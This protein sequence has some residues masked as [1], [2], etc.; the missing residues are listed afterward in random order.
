[1]SKS[2]LNLSSTSP[3]RKL[4][5]YASAAKEIEQEKQ[6]VAALKRL[7]IGHL[8]NHDPDLPLDSVSYPFAMEHGSYTSNSMSQTSRDDISDDMDASENASSY[9]LAASLTKRYSYVELS[10]LDL[11]SPEAEFGTAAN[12]SASSA[13]PALGSRTSAN[14]GAAAAT[15]SSFSGSGRDSSPVVDLLR[16]SRPPSVVSEDLP[17]DAE[18]LWVPANV[19]PEVNPQQYKMH[20]KSTI[21]ELLEQKISRLLSRSR[22]KRSSLSFSVTDSDL[23]PVR[24]DDDYVQDDVNFKAHNLTPNAN[25][26]SHNQQLHPYPT[27]TNNHTNPSLRE[28]TSELQAMS[29]LA[30]MDATDA[31]TLARTLSSASMGYS[32][33]EKLAFDELGNP[34]NVEKNI[35]Q[36]ELDMNKKQMGPGLKINTEGNKFQGRNENTNTGTSK[37][38]LKSQN[39]RL[40]IDEEYFPLRRSRRPDYRKAPGSSAQLS[41][42]Q[43]GLKLQSSKAGK[44]AEL[45]QSLSSQNIAVQTLT[46][47]LQV[48]VTSQSHSQQSMQA[49]NHLHLHK[50]KQFNLS[51]VMPASPVSPQAPGR[52]YRQNASAGQPRESSGGRRRHGHSSNYAAQGGLYMSGGNYVT[53]S[54]PPPQG[55]V[56]LASGPASGATHGSQ[57]IPN[58]NG[59]ITSNNQRHRNMAQN[60][61][62]QSAKYSNAPVPLSPSDGPYYSPYSAERSKEKE[63]YGDK[64]KTDP[65][66][67]NWNKNNIDDR[68]NLKIRSMSSGPLYGHNPNWQNVPARSSSDLYPNQ[69]GYGHQ[70]LPHGQQFDQNGYPMPQQQLHQQLHQNYNMHSHLHSLNYANSQQHGARLKDMSQYGERQKQRQNYNNYQ[71]QP[72]VHLQGSQKSP[73]YSQYYLQSS[74]SLPYPL[75][76]EQFTPLYMLQS[77]PHARVQDNADFS[78]ASNHSQNRKFS[79]ESVKRDPTERKGTRRETRRELNE[80]LDLLRNEINEF[81][82]SLSRTAEPVLNPAT[83]KETPE[84]ADFSFDLTTHDVSYED[85]LGIEK[86]LVA[87]ESTPKEEIKELEFDAVDERNLETGRDEDP[88]PV[89]VQKSENSSFL[90]E[91]SPMES[92]HVKERGT[93]EE[94]NDNENRNANAPNGEVEH[95]GVE[96]PIHGYSSGSVPDIADDPATPANSG[97]N[98]YMDMAKDINLSPIVTPNT[99][100]PE[101]SSNAEL[102]PLKVTKQ[103]RKKLSSSLLQSKDEKKRK[104]PWPWSKE[105]RGSVDSGHEDATGGASVGEG[106]KAV[107][108]AST[109]NF[110]SKVETE[111]AHNADLAASTAVGTVGTAS[112]AGGTKDNVITK[113]FK[114]KRSLSTSEKPVFENSRRRSS[115]DSDHLEIRARTSEESH[116][117]DVKTRIKQK[118]KNMKK[119]YDTKID[120]S[121]EPSVIIE[122]PNEEEELFEDG[123]TPG[124]SSTGATGTAGAGAGAEDKPTSTLEVQE[125]LKKS[126]KRTSRANQPIEFTDSAFGFPLPPPSH[127]T[128]VMIDYRFPV[129]VERAIYR[130]SHLKLANP[131]RSLREQV[132]LSNF[133]Y[134][135]LNLVDHTLHLE[136]MTTEDDEYVQPDNEIDLLGTHDVDTEFEAESLDE[137]DFDSIKLDLEVRDQISV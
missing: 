60:Y 16:H 124:V 137:E 44:L 117:A 11:N 125:R 131:K 4:D 51:H 27:Q 21:D 53:G 59:L 30:G 135:Y 91:T 23:D 79:L 133:M 62:Q 92:Q 96:H 29:R 75:H 113:F 128:L 38:D 106:R 93:A 65:Y 115:S 12:P 56:A 48:P 26:N 25:P 6:M 49:Q 109:P 32:D 46:G 18:A 77:Q 100:V 82:E 112:A 80:N 64:Y 73:A 1:M 47:V 116:G 72:P 7:S 110:A 20:V 43:L 22:S 85:T 36:Y 98:K 2:K 40:P 67:G 8:M 33:V 63:N 10:F 37:I 9:S 5:T 97:V 74:F 42:Q 57:H 119:T 34:Q 89:V 15:G 55:S 122:E 94:A 101:L 111:S 127:S 54:Q 130:L 66:A 118:L 45:R 61:Y 19:H 3:N 68:R 71:G 136:Q 14:S 123:T 108:S 114:K 69:Y 134:A 104:K 81:K 70:S 83:E 50:S 126:I 58:R 76:E 39:P 105:K 88:L 90:K 95:A 120:K 17:L 52:D 121:E 13:S 28:L 84:P 35:Y 87:G 24:N 99:D 78:S 129:H 107:R 132:L 31:V 103:L 86:E 41:Q 102:P